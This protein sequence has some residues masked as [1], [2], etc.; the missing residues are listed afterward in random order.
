MWLL[1]SL[2]K[3]R[4]ESWD[5]Y[6][7]ARQYKEKRVPNHLASVMRMKQHIQMLA[8]RSAFEAFISVSYVRSKSEDI[9]MHTTSVLEAPLHFRNRLHR[10]EAH[11]LLSIEQ[12]GEMGLQA[13]LEV[14]FVSRDGEVGCLAE[15]LEGLVGEAR[16][17]VVQNVLHTRISIG[18]PCLT[19]EGRGWL[20]L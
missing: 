9:P 11:R 17:D 7:V 8:S 20:T 10:L 3:S 19:G 16:L 15:R 14:G 2:P 1:V 12:T 13:L 4:R 18:S 5:P 6:E